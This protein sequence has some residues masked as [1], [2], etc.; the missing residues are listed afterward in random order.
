MKLKDLLQSVGLRMEMEEERWNNST[1]QYEK[2]G[3]MLPRVPSCHSKDKSI[4]RNHL[5]DELP[6][7]VQLGPIAIF[8]LRIPTAE[9]YAYFIANSIGFAAYEI[10]RYS[11]RYG[12]DQRFELIKKKLMEPANFSAHETEEFKLFHTLKDIAGA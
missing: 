7:Y 11:I 8:A 6:F 10:S 4:I 5:E 3:H 2:T 1:H 12:E 9:R